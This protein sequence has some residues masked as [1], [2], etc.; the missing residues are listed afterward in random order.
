MI[1]LNDPAAA[2]PAQATRGDAERQRRR[3]ADQTRSAKSTTMRSSTRKSILMTLVL[4][5]ATMQAIAKDVEIVPAWSVL[6]LDAAGKPVPNLKVDESWEFFGV[7]SSWTDSRVTDSAGRVTFP[8]RSF[9]VSEASYQLSRGVSHLNVHASFV[10]P[11]HMKMDQR[12]VNRLTAIND[13]PSKMSEVP[14]RWVPLSSPDF[15]RK[16]P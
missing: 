6:V 1:K 5:C 3:F 13:P 8:R 11:S 10:F 15:Y 7:S 14:P 16:S 12:D 9:S 4:A 2:S